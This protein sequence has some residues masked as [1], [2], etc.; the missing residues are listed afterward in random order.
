MQREQNKKPRVRLTRNP[1]GSLG[2][3]RN[4]PAKKDDLV[5]LWGKQNASLEL[6]RL[7]LKQEFAQFKQTITKKKSRNY[8]DNTKTPYAS[9]TTRQ[10]LAKNDSL[11]S[12]STTRP[13]TVSISIPAVRVPK[14]RIPM[15]PKKAII[16]VIGVIVL[17][18]ALILVRHNNSQDTAVNGSVQGA[19]TGAIETNITPSF[20]VVTPNGSGVN[21]L[22]GFANIA[23]SGAPAVYAYT[24]TINGIKIKVSQQQLPDALR[25]DQA[26]KLKE[27]A[28][29]F[30]AK[31]PLEVGDATAY[32][33]A[34]A[35]GA[36]SV[37]YIKGE[38]LVLIA[39]DDTIPNADWV[40]YIGS[41]RY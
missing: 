23:P 5:E 18:G 3:P 33:G 13:I 31:T 24:D 15:L 26:N 39:S 8:K 41:L 19:V 1:D 36:Q 10:H 17:M 38:N 22:G 2:V 25:T 28:E 35:K 4:E 21:D 9:Q 20:P 27:L 12:E 14:M 6:P 32:I 34:S 7:S 11:K 30:N 29:G 40:T 16:G 37:V